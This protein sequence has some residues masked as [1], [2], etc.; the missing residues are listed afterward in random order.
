MFCRSRSQAANPRHIAVWIWLSTVLALASGRQSEAQTPDYTESAWSRHWVW[1]RAHLIPSETTSEQSG[2][3]S[4]VEGRNQK[5]YIGTAKY[6][7]NAFLV[8]FDPQT[9]GMKIVVDAEKELGVDRKGFAAQ[10]KFHTRNNVGPSGKIYLGTKQ[11]YT[12]KGE[13]V[14]DYLGGHPMVFDPATGKT[15][16]YDVPIKHQGI[17]SITPDEA[18]GV[19]YISTCSDERPIES[20]HFMILNLESGQYRDLLDCRHMYAFI[21]LDHLGRAYHPILGGQIARYDPRTDQLE[22]LAQTIDGAAP[23]ADSLLAHPESHPINWE[24]SPDRKTLYSVAMSGNQLYA[25]DLAGE[26][27]VLRG[28]RL[29]KLIPGA[30]KTDC[31][32][33]C[34]APDG[35]VWCGV[36]ATFTGRGDFLH[37]VSYHPGDPAPVDRGP[38]A[39]A[40]PD[41]TTFTDRDGK[42]LSHHHGVYRLEDGTMLPRYVVMGICAANDGTVYVTTLYPFTVHA[43]RFPRVAGLTTTYYHNAHA[44]MFFTRLLRT[45]TLDGRGVRPPLQ[46]ASLFSEQ[47]PANDLSAPLAAESNVPRFDDPRA[48]LTLG[49]DR[50]AVDGVLMIGE[51]GQYPESSTGQF[52]F[53]KR[54]WFEEIVREFDRSGRV[55]PVFCDKHLADNWSDAKWIY[56]EAKRRKIPLMAGSS[57]PLTWRYPP[58]DSPRGAKL[59]QIVVTTYGRLDSYGI[60][61]LEAAQALAERRSGGET[62]VAKV[63][64]LDGP[65]VWE[66]AAKGLY[67]RALLDAA[68][69]RLKD[70]PLPAGKTIEQLAT[71]PG[72]ML[73]DYRDGLRVCVFVL[74]GGVQEWAAAWKDESGATGSTVFWTQEQRPFHHFTYQ[75]AA[76]GKLMQTGESLW[77]LERTLLT[78]G[79]LDAVLTS[80]SQSGRPLDTP[81]LDIRYESTWNWRQPPPP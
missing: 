42:P 23:D 55:V 1:S 33:L 53:P 22:R 62:G 21:V 56:D 37:V 68:L 19:A 50:L 36:N 14:T 73:V 18:R 47:K 57:V 67:D 40:N 65:A 4:I 66:A 3:F 6:G 70:H 24:V 69:T 58:V 44:D 10:A 34:V 74:E 81:W 71:K 39:I 72:L 79:I 2:Y 25:Y 46:L 78:T 5:I 7:D 75:L 43:L 15:R 31:R 80:K 51:H 63:Q 32:A 76:V 16:V 41:Y 28:R 38:I 17:I 77:P 26:G 27:N 45:D 59:R 29:G 54:R 64:F 30:A 61:A 49:G 35:T 20:T 9:Q 12:Q 48:A 52:V 8:E 60:H 11:G 13:A